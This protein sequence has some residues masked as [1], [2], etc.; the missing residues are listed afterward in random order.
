MDAITET[1]ALQLGLS[2]SV[3]AVLV[4]FV[5]VWQV[6]WK[7]FAMWKAAR[8]SHLIWFLVFLIF[9]LL[10]IPEILYIFVFSKCYSKAEKESAVNETKVKKA[11]PKQ[12]KKRR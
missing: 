4:G 9:N 3:T 7:G 8:N 2:T 12:K 5:L 10:A 11:K 6:I 1:I